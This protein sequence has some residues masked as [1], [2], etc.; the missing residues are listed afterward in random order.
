M[1]KHCSFFVL[2]AFRGCLFWIRLSGF[3][4]SD[5]KHRL[6]HLWIYRLVNFLYFLLIKFK[7][8]ILF[9]FYYVW[10][11]VPIW[12][13]FF[14]VLLTAKLSRRYRAF[15]SALCLHI[16]I[17]SC[18]INSLHQSG[19]FLTIHEPIAAYHNHP[20]FIVYISIH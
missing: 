4:F 2:Y 17:T 3:I 7:S 12:T 20:R 16:C 19:T 14:I 8:I 5:L 13:Y 15:P 11:F 1:N 9:Y 6:L 10:N 18:M